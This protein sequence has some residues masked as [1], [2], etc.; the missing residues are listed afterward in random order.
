M[1]IGFI[2]FLL[3]GIATGAWLEAAIVGAII[4]VVL[5]MFQEDKAD[6]K[7]YYNRRDYWAYGKEPDWKKRK[8]R[9]R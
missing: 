1:G 3:V 5:F 4:G 8:C 9:R 7:A 2:L 6:M